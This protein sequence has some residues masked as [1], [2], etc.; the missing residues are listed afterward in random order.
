MLN[1]STKNQNDQSE[2]ARSIHN[3]QPQ[4]MQNS[5]IQQAKR[6]SIKKTQIKKKKGEILK[7]APVKSDWTKS[8]RSLKDERSNM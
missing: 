4:I 7:K 8:Q 3:S 5:H 1:F 6:Y 2:K